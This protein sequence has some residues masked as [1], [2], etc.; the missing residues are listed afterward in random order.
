MKSS[1]IAALA[2][3]ALLAIPTGLFARD[4]D[5]TPTAGE[6][7]EPPEPL[8]SSQVGL[9][10]LATS[11]N[12]DT[13]TFGLD[14]QAKRRPVPWGLELSAL[15]DRAE[16]DGVATAERAYAGLR[17]TR[18]LAERWDAFAGLSA[19]QDE[20]SGIDLRSIVEAGV[21][22]KALTGPRHLLELDGAVTWTDENRLPPEVDDSWVGGL[23]AA[24]Y[25]YAI[26]DT[27]AFSQGLKYFANFDDTGNWRAASLSAL[28][29]SLNGSLAVRL[30][31]E[32]RY[33]NEPLD[34]N[35]DTDT[36]TKASLVWSR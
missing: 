13:T 5:P 7:A 8:W 27:A 25:R 29:A 14:A 24:D 35:D 1:A 19:E 32:I 21:A 23:F 26:S 6:E 28:T 12:S 22:Y 10:Y 33:R 34:A 17:G 18:T 20:F 30:S 15:V 36:T 11:G 4:T 31:Y 2:L 9:S 3:A 16:E